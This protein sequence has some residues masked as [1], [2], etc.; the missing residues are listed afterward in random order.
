MIKTVKKLNNIEPIKSPTKP[1]MLRNLINE[2]TII[3]SGN[4]LIIP[5]NKPESISPSFQLVI[6]DSANNCLKEKI[7]IKQDPI[8]ANNKLPQRNNSFF[9]EALSSLT[10][11]TSAAGVCSISL[12]LF[13]LPIKYKQVPYKTGII[14]K[15]IHENVL[16]TNKLINKRTATT[17]I[18]I[19]FIRIDLLPLRKNGHSLRKK[20]KPANKQKKDIATDDNKSLV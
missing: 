4:E 11:C 8:T 1:F 2:H 19:M 5:S 9:F 12:F 18:T 14:A 20:N 3:I 7:N 6:S 17:A 15:I 16:S 10:A 13:F